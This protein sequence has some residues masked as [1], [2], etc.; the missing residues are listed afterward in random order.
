M[1]VASVVRALILG[2]ILSGLWLG[3]QR[4]A[5][6]RAARART[7][8]AVAAPLLAWHFVIWRSAQAGA[9]ELPWR[10][11]R[12]VVPPVAFAIVVPLL[13][14]LPLLFRSQRIAAVLDALPPA[15]LV[16]LQVYRIRGGVFLLRW[17]AGGL[18]GA[19]ALPAGIGDVLVGVL[20]SP[21]AFLVRSGRRGGWRAGYIWNLLG[22]LDLLTAIA[23]GAL[24]T[25][26]RLPVAVP[27]AATRSYPLVMIPAFAVPLSLILH[28]LSLWQLRRAAGA[29]RKPAL[30]PS[31]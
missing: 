30:A 11:G 19:F 15:W 17:A 10:V 9:F 4:T 25:A 16:A 26:G 20:A 5:L 14:A 31:T 28:A 22:I 8:L 29:A 24:N 12:A 27:N 2:A 6:A 23:L 3:L 7:W 13:V 1:S 18:P 21:A